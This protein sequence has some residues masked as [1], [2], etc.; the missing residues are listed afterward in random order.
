MR[1]RE[2][3]MRNTGLLEAAGWVGI[4]VWECELVKAVAPDTLRRLLDTIR[5]LDKALPITPRG[6]SDDADNDYAAVAADDEVPY[7]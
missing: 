2:R 7:E 5:L 6:Y 3:D 1:N 4:V